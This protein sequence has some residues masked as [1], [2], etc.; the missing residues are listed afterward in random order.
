MAK[1]NGVAVRVLTQLPGADSSDEEEGAAVDVLVCEVMD[2]CLVGST[3]VGLLGSGLLKALEECRTS[4][5]LGP[6][7][8]VI[9]RA[10][11]VWAQ[12]IYLPPQTELVRCPISHV[13]TFDLSP[14][15]KFRADGPEPIYLKQ[16]RY[17]AVTAPFAT[18]L[19]ELGERGCDVEQAVTVLADCLVP[20]TVNAI[21]F[22]HELELDAEASLSG[23]P[24][25]SSRQGIVMLEQDL[26]VGEG[27]GSLS[28]T[29]SLPVT[30]SHTRED[31]DDGGFCR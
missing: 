9:P 14:F 22:W 2:P 30:V 4:G 11:R 5:V 10:A 27:L 21:V 3:E 23:G 20:A 24:S 17:T 19:F 6:K 7:T 15:S 13:S 28:V 8:V 26:V 31:G 18:L 25:S 16:L 29:V 12:A 1:A